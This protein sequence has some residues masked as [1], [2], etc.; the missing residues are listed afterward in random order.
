MSQSSVPKP[1]DAERSMRPIVGNSNLSSFDHNALK[2][3][4]DANPYFRNQIAALIE[5]CARL[6]E[7]RNSANSK[8][9]EQMK[10]VGSLRE[11]AMLVDISQGSDALELIETINNSTTTFA[12]ELAHHWHFPKEKGSLKRDR[13]YSG[14]QSALL[15]CQPTHP[16]ARHLLQLAM[17]SHILT[18][19][20]RIMHKAC[21]WAG[22]NENGLILRLEKSVR[23]AVDQP[24]FSRWRAITYDTLF[25]D[26]LQHQKA[27]VEEICKRLPEELHLLGSLLTGDDLDGPKFKEL[28]EDTRASMPDII[29]HS[30]RFMRMIRVEILTANFHQWC[31]TDLPFQARFMETGEPLVPPTDGEMVVA[32]TRLGLYRHEKIHNK[33]GDTGQMGPAICVLKPCVVTE[34][35][36]HAMASGPSST[37]KPPI[38]PLPTDEPQP[39]KK[40]IPAILSIVA[41]IFTVFWHMIGRVRRML[42][43]FL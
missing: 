32:T 18:T 23:N 36:I 42:F 41:W 6:Q 24:T 1:S 29:G 13:E 38:S 4:P 16:Q 19:L 11:L 15:L 20:A 12:L 39:G 21:F 33:R 2:Y 3:L 27:L 17:Q 40:L 7:E 14:V 37:P 25:I 43:G 34:R 26:H 9:L 5:E 35:E 28:V 22:E 31:P 30:I 8:V 10:Q